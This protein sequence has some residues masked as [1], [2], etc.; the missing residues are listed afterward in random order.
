MEFGKNIVYDGLLV[1][2]REHP[3][4]EIFRLI[5]FPELLA[6]E[7]Q[8]RQCNLIPVLFMICFGKGYGFLV[9]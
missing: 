9:K 7:P 6:G 8:Q 5:F 2:H 4:A 3:D 1:F